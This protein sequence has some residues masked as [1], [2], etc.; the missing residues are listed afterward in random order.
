MDKVLHESSGHAVFSENPANTMTATVCIVGGGPAGI[1]LAFLLARQGIRVTLLEAGKDFDR[2]FRGDALSPGVLEIIHEIGLAQELLKLPRA[3]QVKTLNYVSQ[4]QQWVMADFSHLGSRF[5]YILV[6]PQT[7]FLE[8]MRQAASRYPGFQLIMGAP[9]SELIE[10]NGSVCGVRFKKNNEIWSLSA[11]LTIG[12]DGRASKVRKLAGVKMFQTASPVDLLCFRIPRSTDDPPQEKLNVYVGEGYY[13]G[14]WDRSDYWQINVAIPKGSYPS[15][16]TMGIEYLQRQLNAALPDLAGRMGSLQWSDISYLRVEP[17]MASQWHRPGVLLIG[18]SAHV[19]S[20]A[21]GVGITCAIQDA[22]VAAN[23]L[24]KPLQTGEVRVKDLAKVQRL[25]KWPIWLMQAL[26]N[27]AQ[28]RLI[29]KALT[30]K[31]Y[32][33]PFYLQLPWSRNLMTRITGIGLWPVHVK[34]FN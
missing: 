8:F 29:T 13:I 30:G 31:R 21:G 12:A 34:N 33:V 22:V 14:I 19:M 1:T 5:P 24:T 27:Q 6:L 10:K 23:V 17:G 3:S 25:R 32:R 18:D 16:R 9:V 15:L 11:S 26:Q 2:D 20:P 7:D 4:K 28:K